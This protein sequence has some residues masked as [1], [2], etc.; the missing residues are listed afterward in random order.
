M[1]MLLPVAPPLV[2]STSEIEPSTVFRLE[3]DWQ[4]IT[5]EFVTLKPLEAVNALVP[6]KVTTFVVLAID[7]LILLLY[8]LAPLFAKV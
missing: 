5:P 1:P 2:L 8:L 3:P 6:M 4:A 7:T